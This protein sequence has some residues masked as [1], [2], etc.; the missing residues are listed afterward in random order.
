MKDYDRDEPSCFSEEVVKKGLKG[1]GFVLLAAWASM[2][3]V[4]LILRED[5]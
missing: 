3:S 2:D 1:Y 5:G 4:M